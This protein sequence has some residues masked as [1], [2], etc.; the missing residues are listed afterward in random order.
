MS[1]FDFRSVPVFNQAA[2]LLKPAEAISSSIIINSLDRLEGVKYRIFH[3]LKNDHP[4]TLLSV[5]KQLYEELLPIV[6]STI[7]VK[8]D[9]LYKL[10]KDII[11]LRRGAK[12]PVFG[13]RAIQATKHVKKLE[14][15]DYQDDFR[16]HRLIELWMKH[17]SDRIFPNLL[18]LSIDEQSI[19]HCLT[20][21]DDPKNQSGDVNIH[22]FSMIIKLSSI[23]T[24]CLEQPTRPEYESQF[25][26]LDRG[27]DLDR[28]IPFFLEI[29]SD[30]KYNQVNTIRLDIDN[31]TTMGLITQLMIWKKQYRNRHDRT[32]IILD[33][34]NGP[35][36]P[37][38]ES[39]RDIFHGVE[40]SLD[41]AMEA[42]VAWDPD[43]FKIEGPV[44]FMLPNHKDKEIIIEEVREEDVLDDYD[45]VYD[46]CLYGI[47]WKN[48]ANQQEWECPCGKYT[49]D[50]LN[51][52]IQQ[53]EE[54]EETDFTES[55][56][57][58]NQTTIDQYF[59]PLQPK[60]GS[61]H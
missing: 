12:T 8:K 48:K 45:S 59:K 32:K 29:G 9:G 55:V 3:F 39:L 44:S 60:W 18:H 31:K 61:P 52:Q 17:T 46:T 19:A 41:G 38:S 24:L 33:Y 58:P 43:I 21:A 56:T 42:E 28:I 14:I 5:N 30:R 1:W 25:G 57:D 7:Q 11:R 53:F 50:C 34:E 16:L 36:K 20:P 47:K 23:K 2:P 4:H 40:V 10:L 22:I 15:L 27:S 49:N 35:E 51:W 54:S 6:Y 26:W 37:L 13:K